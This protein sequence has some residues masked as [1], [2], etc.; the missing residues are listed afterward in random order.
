MSSSC[1]AF[2]SEKVTAGLSDSEGLISSCEKEALFQGVGQ[3]ALLPQVGQ[4][5]ENLKI[6]NSQL[7]HGLP[8]HPR[9][10]L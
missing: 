1:K 6:Q 3:R 7:Q 8:T 10:I 4:T 5:L 2:S 9:P